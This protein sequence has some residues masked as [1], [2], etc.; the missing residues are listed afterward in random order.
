MMVAMFY[1]FI[2]ESGDTGNPGPQGTSK[3]FAMSICMCTDEQIERLSKEVLK[4]CSKIK[5]KE[6]KYS[7]LSEADKMYVTKGINKLGI[8]HYAQYYKKTARLNKAV[9]DGDEN[10]HH[11]KIYTYILDRYFDRFTLKFGNSQKTPMLQV[12]DV[13]AG[14][15]RKNKR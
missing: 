10:S 12:A 2:D 11:R 6:I 1:L 3:D 4:I 5:K 15:C 8:E 9:I 7:R 14:I 13:Y